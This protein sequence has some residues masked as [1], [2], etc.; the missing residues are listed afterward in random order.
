MTTM[1]SV[2]Y[3]SV[4]ISKSYRVGLS[5]VELGIAFRPILLRNAILCITK[6]D[7]RDAF[8]YVGKSAYLAERIGCGVKNLLER[9]DRTVVLCDGYAEASR[10]PRIELHGEVCSAQPRLSSSRSLFNHSLL[11]R[12]SHAQVVPWDEYHANG[13]SAPPAVGYRRS[14]DEGIRMHDTASAEQ[15]IER[16]VHAFATEIQKDTTPDPCVV[17]IAALQFAV[18]HNLIDGIVCGDLIAYYKIVI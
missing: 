7:V 3:V 8:T 5:T 4:Y 11:N 6:M 10:L 2:Y 1:I 16:L 17:R 12:K 9:G 15:E 18:S 13:T 14:F